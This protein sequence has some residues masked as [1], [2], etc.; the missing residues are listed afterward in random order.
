MKEP[1]QTLRI[2]WFCAIELSPEVYNE[3]RWSNEEAGLRNRKGAFSLDF[4][5]L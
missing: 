1:G 4:V 3:V 5:C 2:C